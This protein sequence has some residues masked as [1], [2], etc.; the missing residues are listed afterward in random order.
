MCD[1]SI[2]NLFLLYKLFDS[3]NEFNLNV[4]RGSFLDENFSEK[5]KQ[6]GFEKFDVVV[7][8]P[9]YQD[10][11]STGDNKLYLDFIKRSISL[12]NDDGYL[13]FVTPKNSIDYILNLS[14]NRTYV[15][16]FYK[17]EYLA[18]DTPRMFFDVGSTFCYFL[19]KKEEVKSD[20]QENIKC[21]FLLD[22]KVIKSVINITK[23]EKIPSILDNNTI[24]IIDKVKNLYSPY[25]I[26]KMVYTSKNG[27]KSFRRIRKNF[28]EDGTISVLR[29]N[30]H[31]Y[32]IIE[33]INEG[34]PYPGK[35]FYFDKQM[36]DLNEKKVILSG[37]GY[38][39]PSYCEGGYNLSDSMFYMLVNN[40]EQ[41]NSFRSIVESKIF[42]FI[43][44]IFFS[45]D[46]FSSIKTFE[47]IGGMNL[48]RIWSNND[49]YQYF[50]LN[51]NEI[52]L[53]EKTIKN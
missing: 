19:I 25:N 27:K 11:G 16:K 18:L 50:N 20:V 53:I 35:L 47:K 52:D 8:N 30:T 2:K 40:F 41:F 14:K 3:N 10:S 48:D 51:Q 43:K 26:Q 46:G 17:I 37:K 44:L 1:I 13:I 42:N 4:H 6:W 31:I 9:P 5:M 29:S 15:D 45:D 7:G 49:L 34:N 38:L 22:K 21:E 39:C 12:I 33:V 28:I 24:S 36:D 32:P 23:G